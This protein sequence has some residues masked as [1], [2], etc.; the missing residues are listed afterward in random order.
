MLKMKIKIKHLLLFKNLIRNNLT[1]KTHQDG[2][3][4]KPKSAEGGRGWGGPE[5]GSYAISGG[6]GGGHDAA[7]AAGAGGGSNRSSSTDQSNEWIN[8][9]DNNP[10]EYPQASSSTDTTANSN[11]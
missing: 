6:G 3:Q 1:K 8:D 4:E 10:Y 5:D 9:V 7:F 2:A 11:E